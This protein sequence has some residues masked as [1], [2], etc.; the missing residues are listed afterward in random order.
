MS[1]KSPVDAAPLE[2][3]KQREAQYVPRSDLDY[4]ISVG[5]LMLISR[6]IVI[7][8]DAGYRVVEGER[9]ILSHY[10]NAIAPLVEAAP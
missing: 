6:R 7:E 1:R 3:E 2:D 10:A 5:L 4:A 8:E 9:R